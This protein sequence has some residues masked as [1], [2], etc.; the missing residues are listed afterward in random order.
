MKIYLNPKYEY[1]RDFIERIPSTF[2]QTGKT[3]YTGRNV[4][5]V[6]DTPDGDT[7]NV[8]CYHAPIGINALIYSL[9]IRKPKG[10]RAFHYAGYLQSKGVDTPEPI[11]YIEYRT[12]GI[13]GKT[14]FVSVQCPYEHLMYEMG[15]ALPEEYE[16]MAKAF[17]RYTASLHEKQILHKD[18]SPGNILW[19][20]TDGNYSFS[21]VDIN[22]MKFGTVDMETGCKNFSRLWGP[23]RFLVLTVQE[24]A[25]Q[26][27]FNAD[28]C[29][30]IMLKY[31]SRFWHKFALKHR[32]KFNLEY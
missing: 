26:R 16:P 15:D 2:N 32:V 7:I 23:K 25:R 22:R 1:L 3:I 5:K 9:G 13:I 30:N 12:L 24:Y 18:Y 4:I 6:F 27:N 29:V 10:W 21:I 28:T 20:K 19:R 31:R 14:Y 11:A 17:A 8:K